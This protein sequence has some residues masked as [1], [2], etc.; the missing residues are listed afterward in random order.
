MRVNIGVTPS[1][2]SDQ[3]L[4]AEYSEVAMPVGTL[5][6][7]NYQVTIKP[8]STML[9]R[10]DH[11]NFFKDKLFYLQRRKAALTKEMQFRGFKTNFPSLC[12]NGAPKE[13]L[14]DWEPTILQ[15]NYVRCRIAQRLFEK[16]DWYR[17]HGVYIGSNIWRFTKAILDCPVSDV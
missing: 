15:S 2:L 17:F 11:M 14:N 10:F 4:I 5:K 7:Y 13:L 16:P 12:L 3:H 8:N 6:K 9:L 1:L